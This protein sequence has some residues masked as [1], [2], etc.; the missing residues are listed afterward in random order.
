MMHKYGVF[1]I[2]ADEDGNLTIEAGNVERISM[3]KG[4]MKLKIDEKN[5]EILEEDIKVLVP[6]FN[7]VGYPIIETIKPCNN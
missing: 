5:Y 7:G 6:T 3:N 2:F 1:A 4:I